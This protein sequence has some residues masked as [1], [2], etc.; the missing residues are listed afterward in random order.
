MTVTRLCSEMFF[1]QSYLSKLFKKENG[2][3]IQEYIAQLRINS[4]CNFLKQTTMTVKQVAEYV[5][6]TNV[7]AFS[8]MFKKLIGSTPSEYR[9]NIEDREETEKDEQ[10]EI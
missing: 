10:Y 8:R 4:A 3:T 5:G 1:S 6:Y 7:I 2:I 9:E